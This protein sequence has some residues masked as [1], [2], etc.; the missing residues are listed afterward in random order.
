MLINTNCRINW[1]KFIA[2]TVVTVVRTQRIIISH[3]PATRDYWLTIDIRRQR[4][5]NSVVHW[6]SETVWRLVWGGRQVAVERNPFY[7]TSCPDG[8]RM[9][10]A[11]THTHTHTH[12]HRPILG[13]AARIHLGIQSTWAVKRIAAAR[14][15]LQTERPSC[16]SVK[17]LK[18]YM[19]CTSNVYM[20]MYTYMYMSCT[21]TC[22]VDLQRTAE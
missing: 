18:D 11:Q 16:H 22:T 4:W 2:S 9:P 21:C 6:V 5:Y 8:R 17:A 15:C 1:L 12:T 7:E 13:G 20:Y 3:A 19:T 10:A 14:S